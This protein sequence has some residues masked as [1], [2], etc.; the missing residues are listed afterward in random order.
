MQVLYVEDNRSEAK[1]VEAMLRSE[2]HLC[3][4]TDSGRQAVIL[5][6]RNNYDVIILDIMLPD[7]DGYEVIE[8]M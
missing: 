1:V 4:T 8:Q 3:H 7:I 5:A 2:G 6:R